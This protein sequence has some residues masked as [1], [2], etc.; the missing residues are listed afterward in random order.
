[1]I[2]KAPKTNKDWDAYF[3]LR[4]EILRAPWGQNKGTEKDH[5]ED[6]SN[7]IH[8]MAIDDCSEIIG[9]ARLNIIAKGTG[10]IRFMAVSNSFQGKGIGKSLIQYLETVAKEREIKKI[11]LQARENAVQFYIKNGYAVK[12]KSFI[13]YEKIQHYLMEKHV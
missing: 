10:Q 7:S 11:I 8:A 4:W 1:M 5:L 9:V 12:E 3:L 6:D 13:L 2:I